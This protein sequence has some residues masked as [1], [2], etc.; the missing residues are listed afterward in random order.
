MLQ[1][2]YTRLHEGPYL[3]SQS[4]N[5]ME[6]MHQG[7]VNQVVRSVRRNWVENA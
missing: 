5:P 7:L 6:M 4:H 1:G 2:T 3:Y